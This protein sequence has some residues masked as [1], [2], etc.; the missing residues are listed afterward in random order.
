MIDPIVSKLQSGGLDSLTSQGE[1]SPL[2]VGDSKFDQVRSRLL[3]DQAPQVELPP[4][5]KQV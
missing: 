3:S 4:E 5:V 2:K 1:A